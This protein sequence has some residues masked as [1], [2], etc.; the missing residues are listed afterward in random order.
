MGIDFAA[1]GHTHDLVTR[2][3]VTLTQNRNELQTKII[4]TA[5]TGSFLRNYVTDTLGYGERALYDPLPIGYVM[6][7]IRG[8]EI[9]GGFRYTIL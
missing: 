7:P 4:H 1:F 6:L 9:A 2:P 3:I 8:G 5:S